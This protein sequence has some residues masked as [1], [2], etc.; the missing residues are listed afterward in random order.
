[1]KKNNVLRVSSLYSKS[2]ISNNINMQ[3]KTNEIKTELI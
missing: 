2:L 3:L 1:M